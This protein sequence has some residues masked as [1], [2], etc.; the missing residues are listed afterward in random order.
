MLVLLLSL[1]NETDRQL[2]ERYVESTYGLKADRRSLELAI[3]KVLPLKSNNSEI[4]LSA[5]IRAYTGQNP[6]SSNLA[7]TWASFLK[8]IAEQ[9]YILPGASDRIGIEDGCSWMFA[10]NSELKDSNIFNNLQYN[11]EHRALN[12]IP[13]LDLFCEYAIAD[14]PVTLFNGRHCSIR[15]NDYSKVL[16]ASAGTYLIKDQSSHV[17]SKLD[18]KEI[19]MN[20]TMSKM[21]KETSRIIRVINPFILNYTEKIISRILSKQKPRTLYADIQTSGILSMSIVTVL[22]Q[23]QSGYQKPVAVV[24]KKDGQKIDKSDI[25]RAMHS[26]LEKVR[27]F[28]SEVREDLKKFQDPQRWHNTAMRKSIE[29][30]KERLERLKALITDASTE[31]AR[32]NEFPPDIHDEVFDRVHQPTAYNNSNQSVWSSYSS[33]YSNSDGSFRIESL[34]F[35][36]DNLSLDGHIF[37]LSLKGSMIALEVQPL[38]DL[39]EEKRRDEINKGDWILLVGRLV[40]VVRDVRGKLG[41]VIGYMRIVKFDQ[42]VF[43]KRNRKQRVGGAK[44]RLY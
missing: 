17:S 7:H 11:G 32:L 14:I 29:E 44:S 24:Y 8:N 15:S 19:N 40:I 2:V 22:S 4:F 13:S 1:L 39:P 18:I 6:I 20:P 23:D 21:V 26:D 16:A 37:R 42:P 35:M 27:A 5:L 34:R 3:L 9:G 12:D 10:W 25:E 36:V 30:V 33:S 31:L 43:T 41:E 28:S 38:E